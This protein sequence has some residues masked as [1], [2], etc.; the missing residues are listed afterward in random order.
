M[1]PAL[2]QLFF[3]FAYLGVISFGG[4]AMTQYVYET[5]VRQKK[6]LTDADFTHGLVVCQ[7]LPGPIVANS[8][9]FYGY[10]LH[11]LKGMFVSFIGFLTPAFL[12]MLGFAYFYKATA[13]TTFV[14]SIFKGLEIAV[15]AIV[16]NA[17]VRFAYEKFQLNIFKNILAVLAAGL[18]LTGANPLL[19]IV[20]FALVGVLLYSKEP[21]KSVSSTFAVPTI[22]QSLLVLAA[23]GLFMMLV[24][25]LHAQLF[26]LAMTMVKI[27]LMSFG[28]VYTALPLMYHEVV[29][30][31]MWLSS[32]T[33][34][35]AVALGQ[36]TPGPVLTNATFVGYM[37]AGSI[38]AVVATVAAFAPGPV[39]LCLLMPFV[40][41]ISSSRLFKSATKGMVIAFGGLLIF[42]AIKF[43]TA[44]DWTFLK[45]ILLAFS[46][47]WLALKN[48]V[49]A[50]AVAFICLSGFIF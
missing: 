37:L 26:L 4:P 14:K 43:A 21:S 41:Q 19:V 46:L 47:L 45:V 48:N 7:S 17:C 36:V 9:A 8:T 44:V 11:G 28:G 33:F 12:I 38:G 42:V 34:M 3:T 1:K 13:D 20:L 32:K 49:M 35:D 27:S 16:T 24:Y 39:L 23:F 50:L 6:W 2:A 5:V 29:D 15:I 30:V 18:L 10:Q 25:L 31:R 40:N 22:M